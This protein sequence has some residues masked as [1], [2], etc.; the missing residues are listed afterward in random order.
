MSARNGFRRYSASFQCTRIE[1]APEI[2]SRQNSARKA[3]KTGRTFPKDARAL[4]FE[5]VSVVVERFGAAHFQYV[6]QR[7]VAAKVLKA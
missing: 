2:E 5:L 4:C 1:G 7:M 3:P 6:G